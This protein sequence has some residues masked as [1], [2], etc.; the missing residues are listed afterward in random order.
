MDVKLPSY[1]QAGPKTDRFY[2]I[3]TNTGVTNFQET[4][5]FFGPPCINPP[6]YSIVLFMGLVFLGSIQGLEEPDQTYD[7]QPMATKH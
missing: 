7:I 2:S 1:I 5:H 3:S 4:V 6:V